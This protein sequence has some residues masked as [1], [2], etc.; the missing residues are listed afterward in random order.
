MESSQQQREEDWGRY[1]LNWPHFGGVYSC[2]LLVHFLL[3]RNILIIA[4]QS[5]INNGIGG[6]RQAAGSKKRRN[7]KPII[8]IN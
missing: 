8:A 7:D 6:G 4:R 3:T 1:S 2:V 5:D